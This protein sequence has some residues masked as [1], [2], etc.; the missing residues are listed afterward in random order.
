MASTNN[1]ILDAVRQDDYAVTALIDAI[2]A[3]AGE[4]NAVNALL[5]RAT[6]ALPT[7]RT[8]RPATGTVDLPVPAM[9]L[10]DWFNHLRSERIT[11]VLNVHYK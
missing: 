5:D 11:P 3:L 8:A 4:N 6:N 9:S 7:R 10:A 2:K 1:D